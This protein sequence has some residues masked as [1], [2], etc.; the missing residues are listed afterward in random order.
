MW[1][2]EGKLYSTWFSPSIGWIPRFECRPLGLTTWTFI[3]PITLLVHVPHFQSGFKKIFLNVLYVCDSGLSDDSELLWAPR[4][5]IA[6]QEALNK[7]RLGARQTWREFSLSLSGTSV[8]GTRPPCHL[9]LG[10]SSV[11]RGYG[12]QHYGKTD[13]DI[14]S[15]THSTRTGWRG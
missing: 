2:S 5:H 3:P 8:L 6:Q 12:F 11:G 4:G 9:K 13:A 1:R 14:H 15:L 7:H 10:P